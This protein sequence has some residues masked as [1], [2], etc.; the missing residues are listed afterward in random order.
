MAHPIAALASI[1]WFASLFVLVFG[2]GL[3]ATGIARRDQGKGTRIAKI[4]LGI[5]VAILSG[6]LLEYPGLTLSMLVI[7]LS[8]S[9]FIQGI[10]R[11]ISGAIGYR[12]IRRD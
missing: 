3:V 7:L 2:A 4:I 9:L 8:I 6:T 5:I 10:E 1:I 12:M 11:I